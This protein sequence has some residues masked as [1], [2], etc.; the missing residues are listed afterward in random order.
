M[1]CPKCGEELKFEEAEI[2]P[3]CG[4]RIKEAP[5]TKEP[6]L[7]QQKFDHHPCT[8][9]CRSVLLG[10]LATI[11]IILIIPAIGSIVISSPP[12]AAVPGI[13]GCAVVGLG[14]IACTV[15][16]YFMKIKGH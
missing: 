9:G 8:I 3:K 10:F 13:I 2:C 7:I 12:A 1:Y 15:V 6:I 5:G 16:A 4:V 11:G 14:L